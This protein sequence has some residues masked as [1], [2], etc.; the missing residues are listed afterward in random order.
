MHRL[1]HSEV[2]VFLKALK[3]ELM[4]TR[5]RVWSPVEDLPVHTFNLYVQPGIYLQP[6]YSAALTLLRTYII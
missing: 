2:K 3:M 4:K 6:T 5:A 1:R